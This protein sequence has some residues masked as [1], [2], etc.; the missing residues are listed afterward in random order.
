[1]AF[2]TASNRGRR[3]ASDAPVFKNVTNTNAAPSTSVKQLD[4]L[5]EIDADPRIRV[6]VRKRPLSAKERNGG[7]KDIVE[8]TGV[9]S[10]ADA[11]SLTVHEP[12]QRVDLT[13]YLDPHSFHFDAVFGANTTN[14]YLYSRTAKQMVH[15]ALSGGKA[16]VFAFGQTGSGKTH[17][18]MGS[19]DER[20]M[21]ALA[22]DDIF[23]RLEDVCDQLDEG[24][25]VT[26]SFYE[27]YGSELFDLLNT[28]KKL[29][30]R[31]DRQQTVHIVGLKEHS[32]S[33]IAELNSLI[34]LGNTCRSTGSTAANN[35]SS[36]SHAVLQINLRF[37][38]HLRANQL[39]KLYGKISFVDLAGSERGADTIMSGKQTSRE[40]AE[41]NK[42]LL[43]LKECIRALDNEKSHTPFRGSKLT[44]VLRDSFIG[45]S[46]TVM[47]ATVSPALSS[48]ENTLNTLRYA[49]R[50]KELKSTGRGGKKS[51]P[52]KKGQAKVWTQ[53][54]VD[55]AFAVGVH[56]PESCQIE[57][58]PIERSPLHEE[59]DG[60]RKSFLRRSFTP[61]MPS[62][63]KAQAARKGVR[64]SISSAKAMKE[65]I[66]SRLPRRKQVSPMGSTHIEEHRNGQV[67]ASL[68]LRRE[69]TASISSIPARAG[70]ISVY[71]NND[72]SGV[73]IAG[74]PTGKAMNNVSG[75]VE[76]E[77]LLAL[78]P[79]DDMRAFS[80]VTREG[81]SME[82][83]ENGCLKSLCLISHRR[84]SLRTYALT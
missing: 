26:A 53:F 80:P 3:R 16:T 33:C 6:V 42:S 62:S 32:V 5:S 1:M 14:Q 67:H 23:D 59:E 10:S 41:I 45:N 77:H 50:V 84:N 19:N 38:S 46:K 58:T 2:S 34:Q 25:I 18:M 54:A 31:E 52:K 63:P 20:G 71:G 48:S 74:S 4:E 83:A 70:H 15:F 73:L 28:K 75:D 39:G 61:S 57:G 17:T 72:E 22:V 44:Q 37:P 12:K 13:K 21:Y 49:D 35:K 78:S 30:T 65:D 76:G 40:G 27:I 9:E 69:S 82:E 60:K 36:R 51:T 11:L 81:G 8:V 7:E 64:H 79:I 24:L 68:S 43:A 47:I 55:L 29:Q 56:V 66:P